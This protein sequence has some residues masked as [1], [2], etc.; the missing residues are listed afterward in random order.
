[1]TAGEISNLI[2]KSFSPSFNISLITNF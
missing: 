1:M 2:T